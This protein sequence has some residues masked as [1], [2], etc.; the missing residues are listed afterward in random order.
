M[1]RSIVRHAAF[2]CTVCNFMLKTVGKHPPLVIDGPITQLTVLQPWRYRVPVSRA[3]VRTRVHATFPAAV[4]SGAADAIV[5]ESMEELTA[6][7][8][9]GRLSVGAATPE[10]DVDSPLMDQHARQLAASE[11]IR[12]MPSPSDLQQLGSILRQAHEEGLDL[13]QQRATDIPQGECTLQEWSEAHVRRS[14][15]VFLHLQAKFMPLVLGL[16]GPAAIRRVLY[17]TMAAVLQHVALSTAICGGACAL[18]DC[19]CGNDVRLGLWNLATLSLI[20]Q[21]DISLL[22][23]DPDLKEHPFPEIKACFTGVWMWISDFGSYI[24]RRTGKTWCS[25][26]EDRL[27]PKEV[28]FGQVHGIYCNQFL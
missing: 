24:N 13:R 9:A 27:M 23:E 8:S 10:D 1:L 12:S 20:C 7:V 4:P 18:Q 15:E 16:A 14:S 5:D 28:M 11:D 6:S 17:P 2:L 21:P 25:S 3:E 26:F 22:L 19:T